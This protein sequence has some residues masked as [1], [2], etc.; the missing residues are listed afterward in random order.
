MPRLPAPDAQDRYQ[1]S[2]GCAASALI[3]PVRYIMMSDTR[4]FQQCYGKP[5]RSP[6]AR[7]HASRPCRMGG[8]R[9]QCSR[10]SSQN[11]RRKGHERQ[12]AGLKLIA[13]IAPTAIP[14]VTTVT[15]DVLF[16]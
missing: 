8:H 7:Y 5:V 1:H 14:G 15:T 2:A 10:N 4:Y 11:S 16:P 9:C 13:A 12:F 3:V 6:N